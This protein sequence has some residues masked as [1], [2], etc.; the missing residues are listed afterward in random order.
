MD[1]VLFAAQGR[2]GFCFTGEWFI[3]NSGK[4]TLTYPQNGVLHLLAVPYDTGNVTPFPCMNLKAIT[5]CVILMAFAAT[6][7]SAPAV[8]LKE[9]DPAPKLYVSKWI[10]GEP[11]KAFQPGTAYLVEF[12]TTWWLPCREAMAHVNH[13]HRKYKD[14]GLVVIGQ[15]VKQ[16]AGSNVE[17]F[18]KR[19]GDLMTYRVALDEGGT[20]RFSGRTLETWLYAA[21]AGVPTAFIIDKKGI[22]SFI[23]HPDEIDDKVIEQVL[24]GTFD[25]KKR[26][27]D[28]EAATAKDDDWETHN[29]LGKTAWKA[30]QWDKAMSE[31]NEMEKL[32]PHKRAVT[33]CLR[34]TVFM[35]Q[36]NFEAAGKL[37]MQL[38]NDHRDD[39]FLQ[40][41]VA[42][43][44]ANRAPTNT[45]ILDKANLCM[46]RAAALLKGPE[47][48]F[49][50]TQA[51]IAFLQGK[52]E[53][54]V[55]LETQAM[56]LAEPETKEQFALALENFKEGK[57]PQ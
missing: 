50:H 27:L 38:S 7:V 26:A 46:E 54:A 44:I 48:E 24:A 45:V 40:Q 33:E 21:E 13:L 25:V 53:K 1:W 57:M 42:R 36:Q 8:T 34:I 31:I 3:Y 9:G 15:N 39:P 30:K 19:M 37:A 43:T 56:G 16:A 41:R 4:K 6:L 5:R 11:I 49:L 22:I 29:E 2:C 14:K 23:G 10:Q 28:R 20:N 51:R 55:Q 52:K 35:G 17:G 12:W 47:P 32:Y 18:V